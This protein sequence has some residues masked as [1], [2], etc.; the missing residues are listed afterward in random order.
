[1]VG[2][3][4]GAIL[5]SKSGYSDSY[6]LRGESNNY[7]FIEGLGFCDYIICPHYEENSEKANSLKQEKIYQ[8]KKIIGIPNKTALFI[9]GKKEY[10]IGADSNCNI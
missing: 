5:L 9:I 1:M 7:H 2:I 10:L 8:N 6:I 3:S 4:A